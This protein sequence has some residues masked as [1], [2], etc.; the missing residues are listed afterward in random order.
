M[1][2]KIRLKLF[3]IWLKSVAPDTFDRVVT[4]AVHVFKVR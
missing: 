3:F 1:Y 4:E 2:G